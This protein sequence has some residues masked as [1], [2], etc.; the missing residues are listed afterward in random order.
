ME[1][2]T[3]L[4]DDLQSDPPASFS[5][6]S[7]VEIIETVIASLADP[8]SSMVSH[9]Q[10]GYLWKF[11]YGQAEIF[12]QLTGLTD[13]DLLT[14]WSNLLA[15]SVQNEPH[16]LHHLLELNWAQTQEA[17]FALIDQEVV[18]LTCRSVADLSAGEISRAI[19]IVGSLARDYG[20]SLRSEYPPL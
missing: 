19:T 12:V 18:V 13:D 7:V 11:G 2:E 3:L 16:L 20:A 5:E 6:T 14:V 15:L 8:G 9:S 10:T 4:A 1:S 17:R